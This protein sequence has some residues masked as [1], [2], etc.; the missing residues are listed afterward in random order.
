MKDA[1]LS[2][3]IPEEQNAEAKKKMSKETTEIMY[4]METG[5]Q[6]PLEVGIGNMNFIFKNLVIPEKRLEKHHI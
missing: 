3:G 4:Q 5:S 1:G 2:G 6:N